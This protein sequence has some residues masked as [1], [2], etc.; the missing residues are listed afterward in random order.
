MFIGRKA[1]LEAE[2]KQRKQAEKENKNVRKLDPRCD[3]KKVVYN[4]SSRKL[5]DKE[6]ELLSLGLNF[7]LTPKK[8]PLVEY[9]TATEVLCKSLEDTGVDEDIE[10]AQKIRNLLLSHIRKGFQMRIKNN[11]S[12]EE[13]EILKGLK[14]DMSIIICPADKGKAVVVED[15][16]AYMEKMQK[17][18]DEGDYKP[19]K[20]KEKTLLNKIHRKLVA[21]LKK[22]GMT[23]FKDRRRFLVTAPVLANMHLLIKVHKKNS[24]EE[25]LSVRLMTQL[26]TFAK[27]SRRSCNQLIQLG[28]HT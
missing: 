1:K 28:D 16:D 3:K 17:Q 26:T 2:R 6:I 9:I 4:N 27:N 5:M 10:N 20:G 7:G 12:V 11:L 19:A 23:E 8:F 25:P 13:R 21:Q 22:M 14:N 15:R 24:L 18:V